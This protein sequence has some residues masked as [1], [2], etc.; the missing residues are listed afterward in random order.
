MLFKKTKQTNLRK[1]Q[2]SFQF[3]F[4]TR[5]FRENQT[6]WRLFHQSHLKTVIFSLRSL[7][8]YLS[9]YLCMCL[10]ICIYK[11]GKKNF[12]FA[13][14]VLAINFSPAKAEK[15]WK[16]LRKKKYFASKS[17]EQEQDIFSANITYEWWR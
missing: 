6:I 5:S 11:F 8:I 17:F 2:F 13:Q 3:Q 9:I 1:L 15:I 14:K 4:K 16:F 12:N 10:S 7:S